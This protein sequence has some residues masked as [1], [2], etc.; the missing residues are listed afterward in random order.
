MNLEND[1]YVSVDL[2]SCYFYD[3][4]PPP[5]QLAEWGQN[6]YDNYIPKSADETFY[7]VDVDE[8]TFYYCGNTRI[9]VTEHFAENGKTM[10]SLI[11]SVIR[12][13]AGQIPKTVSNF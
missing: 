11:E 10:T 2:C 9:K 6:W 5:E 7:A 4:A 13:I 3:F 8:T 12:H 1:T